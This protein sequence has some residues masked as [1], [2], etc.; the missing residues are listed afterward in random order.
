MQIIT[1]TTIQ[2]YNYT[3]VELYKNGKQIKLQHAIHQIDRL[4]N[5]RRTKGPL[6]PHQ[7]LTMFA[8]ISSN[9][10]HPNQIY[11][12]QLYNYRAIPLY[13]YINILQY[14]YITSPRLQLFVE[15]LEFTKVK[16][17]EIKMRY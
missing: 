1:I 4:E 11:P 8:C 9:G 5:I 3:T 17:F 10:H 2:L 13:N 16:I 6:T 15:Q 12:I 7:I 14:N